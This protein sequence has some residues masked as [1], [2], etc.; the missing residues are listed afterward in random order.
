MIYAIGAHYWFGEAIGT[1][2]LQVIQ[3]NGLAKDPR[4]GLLVSEP[5]IRISSGELFENRPVLPCEDVRLDPI[6]SFTP[7]T[8]K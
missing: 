5:T 6:H 7:I 4:K 8:I 1:K 3:I 2:L